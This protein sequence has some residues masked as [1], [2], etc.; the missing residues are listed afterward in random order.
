[1]LVLVVAGCKWLP[2]DEDATKNWSAQQFYEVGKQA[3]DKG[4]FE[5]AIEHFEQLEARFPYGRFA[6]QS[7]LSV[8]YAYYKYGEPESAITAADRFIRLHPTHPNVDYAYYLKGLAHFNMKR[9]ILDR[10]GGEEIL[11]ERDPKAAQLAFQSFRDLVTRYPE[12]RYAPD[13]TDRMVYLLNILGRHD[14][15]VARYYLERG[16]YVAAVNRCKY[17][18][19]HF[20]NAPAVEDALGIMAQA[21]DLMGLPR[22]A[23]DS[24]RVLKLNFPNSTYLTDTSG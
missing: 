3:L 9:Q 10:L 11:S 13:A 16:A 12:S 17:V 20:Q 2:K 18:I 7:Q 24:R 22:L 1:M 4:D 8:G 14:V 6:Q 23:H 21:Y 15:N 5:A 19:K